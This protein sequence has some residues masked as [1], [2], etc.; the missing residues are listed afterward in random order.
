MKVIIIEDEQLS[1]EKLKG[2]IKKYD[3]EIEIIAELTTI[4]E[5]IEWLNSNP[6]P[7]LIFSDI[8]L[9][10]GLSF[11]IYRAVKISCPV[12]FTTAFDQYAINAFEVNSV[13][14]LIKPVT[15]ENLSLNLQKYKNLKETL[16]GKP[17]QLDINA[18]IENI[19]QKSSY[20]SRFLVKSGTKITAIKTDEI[21]YFMTDSKIS[22]LITKDSKKY[23]VDYSLDEI[24]QM[25]DPKDFYRVSRKYIIHIDAAKEIHPYFKGR[26]K[27]ELA[28]PVDDEVIVSNDKMVSFKNWLDQ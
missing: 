17:Q 14:Y 6:I 27:I 19:R 9:A 18:L 11:E 20:K 8:Q 25:V 13:G 26:L 21:A 1:A 22:F 24:N 5:S 16:A 15:L 23:P 2:L 10:D 4:S 12:I 28:P 7:D 3:P